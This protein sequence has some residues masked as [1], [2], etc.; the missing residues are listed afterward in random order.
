MNEREKMVEKK[1]P[2][3]SKKI[4]DKRKALL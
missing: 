1:N 3:M 4:L 2:Q